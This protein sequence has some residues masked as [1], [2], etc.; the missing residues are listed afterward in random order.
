MK[1]RVFAIA[2]HPDDIEFMMAGTLLLL[3]AE[4][5][6]MH[7]MNLA[8]GCLGSTDMTPAETAA[9]RKKEAQK[10]ADFLGASFHESVAHDLE[11][12][13]APD[14]IKKV[15]AVVR[16]IEPD[17]MLVPSPEDYM[18]DHMNTTRIAVTAA[19][20]RGVPNYIS[21]PAVKATGHDVA[22]YHAMPYGLCDELRRRIWPDFYIDIDSVIDKKETMLAFHE[23]QKKWLDTT[24]GLDSYLQTM[25]DMAHKVGEMSKKYQYAEGWRRHSHLGFSRKEANPLALVLREYYLNR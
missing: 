7:Y 19:F 18:E 2:C 9:V 17:I 25:R 21:D 4:G 20:S 5:C 6:E 10:A 13:Y 24:Q 15:T 14:L 3:K 8:D 23:S 1:I 22:I 16:L 12:F 11:V